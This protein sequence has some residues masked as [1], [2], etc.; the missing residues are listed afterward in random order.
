L[1]HVISRQYPNTAPATLF[2]TEATVTE[3]T[4]TEIG[5]VGAVRARCAEMGAP[6]QFQR[7]RMENL[8]QANRHRELPSAA[9]SSFC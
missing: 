3:I 5:D 8:R 7:I 4:V 2:V 9:P 1:N 6:W